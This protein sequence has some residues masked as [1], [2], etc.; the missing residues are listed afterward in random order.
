M[1]LI[2][3]PV[4]NGS[5]PAAVRLANLAP[6]SATGNGKAGE[7]EPSRKTCLAPCP[8]FGLSS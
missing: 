8:A 4:K 5:G 6:H 7:R 1:G 2:E 3:N